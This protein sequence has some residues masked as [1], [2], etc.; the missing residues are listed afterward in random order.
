MK[1]TNEDFKY[2]EELFLVKSFEILNFLQFDLQF[3][4]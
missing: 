2:R 3:C 1:Q 4:F